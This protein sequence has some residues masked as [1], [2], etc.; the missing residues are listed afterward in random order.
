MGGFSNLGSV[1]VEVGA[2]LSAL[3]TGLQTAVGDAAA[4]GKQ[5]GEAFNSA[6]PPAFALSDATNKIVD[7]QTKLETQAEQSIQTFV[8]MSAAYQSGAVSAN[9]VAR[10]QELMNE[11]LD[12]AKPA[13][14]SAESGISGLGESLEKVAGLFGIGL[15]IAEGVESLKALAEESIE[16]YGKIQLAT[17]ALTALTGSAEDAGK[18]LESIKGLAL[19]SIFSVPQLASAAQEMANFGVEANKIP[20]AMHA[21]VDAAE[22]S[23][24]SLETVSGAF[25]RI[26]NSGQITSRT[27]KSLGIDI[28]DVAETTGQTAAQVTEAFKEMGPGSADSINILIATLDR[29]KSKA[30]EAVLGT[31]PQQINALKVQWDELLVSLGG[32]IA[33]PLGSLLTSLN[34]MIA[35]FR[36]FG[37]AIKP[38]VGDGGFLAS[39]FPQLQSLGVAWGWVKEQ[40]ILATAAIDYAK[41]SGKSFADTLAD[42]QKKTE[43][44][45][46]ATLASKEADDLVKD[47]LAASVKASQD[48]AAA[49][50]NRKALKE[51]MTAA[52]S[53]AAAAEKSL[54]DDIRALSI[55]AIKDLATAEGDVTTARAGLATAVGIEQTALAA[56]NAEREK[57]VPNAALL[58][59]L[60]T[61]LKNASIESA[62][63][64]TAL[65]DAESAL[66]QTRTTAKDVAAQMAQDE[67]AHANYLKAIAIPTIMDQKTAL[68]A[69]NTAKQTAAEADAALTLAENAYNAAVKSG[70]TA[71]VAAATIALQTARAKLKTDTDAVKTSEDNL[72]KSQ[73]AVTAATKE[74]QT[75]D[76][77]LD[78]FYLRNMV[79]HLVDLKGA[80][81]DTA[82]AKKAATDAGDDLRR[83][84][85]DLEAA[86]LQEGDATQ[87]VT[88]LRAQAAVALQDFTNKTKNF[89]DI[90]QIVAADMGISVAQLRLLIDAQT[91]GVS[92]AQMLGDAYA[93]MGIKTTAALQ[94]AV[95]AAKVGYQTIANSGTAS[96]NQQLQALEALTQAQIAAGQAIPADQQ[97]QLAKMTQ[98]ETDYINNSAKRWTDLSNTIHSDVQGMFSG[99]I[100]DLFEGGDFV[101]TMEDT[102]KKI[103]ESIVSAIFK[104]FTDLISQTISSLITPLAKT[105]AGWITDAL[106]AIFP[107]LAGALGGAVGATATAANTAAVT[108]NT[109]ALSALTA[110]M[111]TNAAS[112]AAGS[113]GSAA[114]S[115]GGA[116]G[117][118]I[119]GAMNVVT[120][121][122]SAVTGII[123]VIQGFT[124]EG[125]LA[126]IEQNTRT[127]AIYLGGDQSTGGITQIAWQIKDAILYGYATKDL[128]DIKAMMQGGLN[129]SSTVTQL[130]GDIKDAVLF[131]PATKDLDD[132]KGYLGQMLSA[133]GSSGGMT[134]SPNTMPSP[135]NVPMS[136]PSPADW[137]AGLSSMR[138]MVNLDGRELWGSFVQFA[139]DNGLVV[140]QS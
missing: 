9:D 85:L 31:L 71:A 86:I 3:A 117:D 35:A 65:K 116:V 56:L 73:D 127:A 55:P 10:S 47:G 99:L 45:T 97:I 44:V 7:A 83:I 126:S 133:G 93:A 77:A 50:E 125:K 129:L 94:A 103:G 95:D 120:G 100:T 32:S 121:A 8:E 18:V 60:E 109:A 37:E 53:A 140:P 84:E 17:V 16:A 110:A 130:L 92:S 4:A 63:A 88:D 42:L 136:I 29:L 28:N 30:D 137:L 67:Q 81:N 112:T 69:V 46:S 6:V 54:A 57:S 62:L 76:K 96:L 122:I 124:M 98:Q 123:S 1:Y 68:D 19:G 2:D 87:H 78:D 70:D 89:H 111:G 106:T 52:T 39:M 66:N 90:E 13:A 24:H 108:A 43:G 34:G 118:V 105:L 80:I 51:A 11:A 128:D 61:D 135:Q 72:K 114:G 5:V 91:Q 139:E 64:K 48:A 22:L 26:V 132:I 49:E 82:D 115:V 119:G 36:E 23:G 14:E 134:F 12:K 131:G 79:P 138:M 40:I 113:A 104:P 59:T 21:I 58:K 15:G 102:L 27:L 74:I 75:I 38:I 20:A 33:G 101:K 25:D 107:S 41:G